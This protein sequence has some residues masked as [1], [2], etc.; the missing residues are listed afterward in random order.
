MR[1]ISAEIFSFVLHLFHISAHTALFFGLLYQFDPS[2]FVYV[3]TLLLLLGELIQILFLF[4]RSDDA[5]IDIYDLPVN[6]VWAYS[7]VLVLIYVSLM[8]VQV[9][10]FTATYQEFHGF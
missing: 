3:Y 5:L 1:Y 7:T 9:F 6:L 4:M 2:P 8:L 10:V